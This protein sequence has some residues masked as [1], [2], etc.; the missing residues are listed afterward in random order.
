MQNFEL[1]VTE[2]DLN[3]RTITYTAGSG[4][5]QRNAKSNGISLEGNVYSVKTLISRDPNLQRIF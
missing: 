2:S 3:L 4:L 5:K 1:R